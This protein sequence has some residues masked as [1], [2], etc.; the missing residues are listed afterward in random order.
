M[1]LFGNSLLLPWISY[2]IGIKLHK[3]VCRAKQYNYVG[4]G[5]RQGS[6]QTKNNV[7]QVHDDVI[8]SQVIFQDGSIYFEGEN[9][10]TKIS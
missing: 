9:V 10:M 4:G 6:H 3:A 5:K 2:F 7:K 8:Q 1:N